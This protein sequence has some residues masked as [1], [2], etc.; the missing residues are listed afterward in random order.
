MDGQAIDAEFHAR[1]NLGQ[2]GAGALATSQV[3]CD[4]AD[5][6]AALCLTIGEIENVPNDS[7]NRGSHGVQDTERLV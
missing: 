6:M 3:I 7:A 4:Q 2:R 1:C 5:M